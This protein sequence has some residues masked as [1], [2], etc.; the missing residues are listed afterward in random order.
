M[1][2][3]TQ[4]AALAALLA[5][6]MV[7][8]AQVANASENDAAY[9]AKAKI[10]LKQAVSIAEKKYDGKAANVEFDEESG[11][12]TFEVEVVSNKS[13]RDVVVDGETGHI[14]KA[15][16]DKPDAEDEEDN[17]R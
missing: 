2:R 13:V 10:D 7:G 12:P 14:L 9:L 11:K 5:A 3:S 4:I 15:E 1:K 6:T 16:M 8:G 17:D